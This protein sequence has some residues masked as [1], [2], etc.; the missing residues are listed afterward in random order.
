MTAPVL[1]ILTKITA[2][3][4]GTSKDRYLQAQFGNGFRQVSKDGFNTKIDQWNI[5]YAPLEGTELTTIDDFINQVGCDVWFTWT[6]L[7]ETISKKFR[8]DPDSLKRTPL[9]LT[10]FLISFTITQC[11][12]LGT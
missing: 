1:P 7:G 3:S 10:K 5:Q 11:F 4:T 12:D 8:R 2:T 6:P 9:N